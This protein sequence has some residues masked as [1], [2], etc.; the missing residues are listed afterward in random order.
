MAK[1]LLVHKNE[2]LGRLLPKI[3]APIEVEYCL[4]SSVL[5]QDLNSLGGY[6]LALIQ[7]SVLEDFPEIKDL[8]NR[9]HVPVVMISGGDEEHYARLARD[10]GCAGFLPIDLFQSIESARKAIMPFLQA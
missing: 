1:V 2:V 6:G 7:G 9:Y 8:F 4:P 3:L 5:S 10:L